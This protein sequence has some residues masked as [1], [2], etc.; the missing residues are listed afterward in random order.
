MA[1]ERG[2]DGDIA[3]LYDV[4]V[5]WK[6][7]LAREMPGVRSWLD[8]ANARKVLD[9]GCGTGRHVAALVEAGYAAVGS[10]ASDAM[11]DRAREHVDASFVPWRMEETVP[12]ALAISAPFDAVLALGN[13][14]PQLV[15]PGA[16]DAALANLRGLVSD[17]GVLLLGLKAFAIRRDAGN[18]YLPLLR[19]THEGKT[20]FF[21]RFLDFASG[22]DD[23]AAMHF[24]ILGGEDHDGATMI[25][26]RV[27]PIRVWSP[28]ELAQAV[29]AAGFADV[30]VS[31][32]I[33]DPTAPVKGE[34]IFVFAR[35]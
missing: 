18:P 30:A 31:G 27:S 24:A 32:S 20:Y 33:S 4:F 3:S 12:N 6:S 10:D 1:A 14:W 9:V 21:V 23:R 13:V 5:D 22:G 15:A 28:E 25:D 17:G 2:F 35:A 19:R 8:G 16:S 29:R 11:L 34:D 26:H 7:R